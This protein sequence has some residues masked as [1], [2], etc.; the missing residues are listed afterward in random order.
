MSATSR[1]VSGVGGTGEPILSVLAKRRYRLTAVGLEGPEEVPLTPQPTA[2]NEW[3]ELLLADAD[4]YPYKPATDVLVTGTAYPP[5]SCRRFIASVRVGAIAK[6]VEVLGRRRVLGDGSFSEPDPAGPTPLS[7]TE[8]FGGEDRAHHANAGHPLKALRDHLEESP[9]ILAANPF[10]YPRNPCGKGFSIMGRRADGGDGLPRLEDPS[11]R[12]T[13]ERTHAGA[14]FAWSRQP[15]PAGLGWF[16]LLWYPR[17]VYF[18][19]VPLVPDPQTTPEARAGTIELATLERGA[20]FR[21]PDPRHACG[22]SPGL[23]VP[24]LHG[25]ET[26]VLENLSKRAARVQLEIP[27]PP[28]RMRID[29]RKGKLIDVEPVLSSIVLSPDEETVT[30]VWRGTGR[31][32]RPYGDEEL[33]RMPFEVIW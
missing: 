17:C 1:Q 22:A 10:A 7:Y 9:E 30:L 21:A 2:C 29:G 27:R 5:A 4:T 14:S 25:G 19:L 3:P 6:E 28:S 31:A 20:H 16:G 26:I 11:D 18:G 24:W 12:L 33:E 23:S 15:V 32:I 8:A 13:P